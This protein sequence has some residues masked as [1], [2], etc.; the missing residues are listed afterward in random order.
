MRTLLAS[1]LAMVLQA[2]SSGSVHASPVRFAIDL[3]FPF[4]PSGQQGSLAGSFLDAGSFRV[5]SSLLPT[6][7][8]ALISFA[9]ISDFDLRLPEFAVDP[10]LLGQGTCLSAAQLPVCGF[11][12]SDGQLRGLVGQFSTPTSNPLYAFRLNNTSPNLFDAAP[13]FQGIS[14][15]NRRLGSTVA[16]GFVTVRPVPEPLSAI[17]FAA[18]AGAVWAGGL[19]RSRTR[20]RDPLR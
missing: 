17:L 1:L 19:R 7:G 6:R 9:Q 2:V 13:I 11:L 14:I 12:F 16:S 8:N 15:E 3:S 18:G 20:A 4:A 10:G 5:E